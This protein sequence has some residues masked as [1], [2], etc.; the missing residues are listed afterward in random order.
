MP[1]RG[2]GGRLP[3]AAEEV[4][5]AARYASVAT[6]LLGEAASASWLKHHSLTAYR[7]IHIA[8]HAVVNDAVMNRTALPLAPGDG[9]DGFLGPADRAHLHLAARLVGLSGCPP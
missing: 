8:T 7:I 5:G 1:E 3:A 9:G 4:I 2:P 6:V